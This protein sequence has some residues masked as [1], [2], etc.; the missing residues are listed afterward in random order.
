MPNSVVRIDLPLP[1]P[2]VRVCQ[3]F[4]R[5][6]AGSFFR[7]SQLL[8]AR[9]RAAVWAIYTVCSVGEA[10][11]DEG[12]HSS[13]QRRARLEG[14][15]QSVRLALSGRHQDDPVFEAFAWAV[16]TYRVPP[17]AF[18]ELYQGLLMDLDGAT[19]HST[20]DLAQYCFRI[21]GA[22]GLM[23]APVCGYTGGTE[24]L[25]AVI[26]LGQALQLT[27]ILR[28]VG[29]DLRLG[30]LYLP[31]TLLEKHGVNLLALRRGQSTAEYRTLMCELVA[32]NRQ[33][34][35][36]AEPHLC[37]LQGPAPLALS[38]VTEIYQAVLCELE[39]T[40][41]PAGVA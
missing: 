35:A 40:H 17:S 7:A 9:R 1:H 13:E 15:W 20:Y 4:I 24:T 23:L 32:L 37:R 11:V 12:A 41:T 31:T 36:Q 26:R 10:I 39:A 18:Q 19:Y 8:S 25:A 22:I 28:H 2:A 21:G 5:V 30:R 3:D 16:T 34:Y 6:H 27:Q 33:W 38:M 29:E 14:W